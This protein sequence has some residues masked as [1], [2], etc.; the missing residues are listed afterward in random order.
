MIEGKDTQNKYKKG[1]YMTKFEKFIMIITIVITVYCMGYSAYS[2][3]SKNV[4][5]TKEIT[6]EYYKINNH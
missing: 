3:Y 5:H 2:L 1:V 6:L 4:R